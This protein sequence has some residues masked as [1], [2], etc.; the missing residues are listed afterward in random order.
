ME[1]VRAKGFLVV[2]HN[3]KNYCLPGEC[4]CVGAQLCACLHGCECVRFDI[5]DGGGREVH[6]LSKSDGPN[7][8]ISLLGM[9]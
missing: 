3:T 4:L 9:F 1:N 7:D 2:V 8:Y 6:L 5:A